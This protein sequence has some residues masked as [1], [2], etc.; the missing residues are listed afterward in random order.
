MQ[1]G[2]FREL[3]SLAGVRVRNAFRVG[4]GAD[5]LGASRAEASSR[6]CAAGRASNR[7]ANQARGA[8][9]RKGMKLIIL[10]D[11]NMR[12]GKEVY[13]FAAIFPQGCDCRG[14]RR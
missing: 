1:Q 10:Q 12:A 6:K 8:Q 11:I 13:R 14:D 2:G 3:V 7:R 5:R 4:N 9:T